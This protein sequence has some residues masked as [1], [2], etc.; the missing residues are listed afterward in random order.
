MPCGE[1]PQPPQPMPAME[2]R[3]V[4]CDACKNNLDDICEV[5]ELQHPGRS[6]I[7]EGIL[8]PELRCP[9]G[10]WEAILPPTQE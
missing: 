9:N 10:R 3:R 2:R 1:C 5:V 4:I 7:S 6:C 8:R